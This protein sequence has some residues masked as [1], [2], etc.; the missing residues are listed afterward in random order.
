MILLGLDTLTPR[1][2]VSVG[3]HTVTHPE[4]AT[5]QAENL[6]GQIASALS[7][8][9]TDFVDLNGVVVYTGPGS[10]TGLR[11]GL[12]AAHGIGQALDIPVIGV[13]VPEAFAWCVPADEDQML[14][15]DSRR[16]DLA[17]A[18]RDR[19]EGIFSA[20]IEAPVPDIEERLQN[21]DFALLGNGIA[22]LSPSL[23][24]K[25]RI[26]QEWVLIGEVV[27]QISNR[28]VDMPKM[29]KAINAD[30]FYLRAPDITI[31]DKKF[32]HRHLYKN[33]D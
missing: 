23:L 29:Y 12:A 33:A 8:H 13:T 1:T 3:T 26:K 19:G 18:A 16:Q 27:G 31:S 20:L 14:L 25:A 28:M 4:V 11:V 7:D 30:P 6:M 24:A 5:G 9:N 21:G 2:A 32:E 22:K 10:F 15:V 17:F